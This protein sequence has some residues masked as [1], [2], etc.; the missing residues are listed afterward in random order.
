[1]PS[2]HWRALAAIILSTVPFARSAAQVEVS[3]L[4]FAGC[5]I[6]DLGPWSPPLTDTID[7]A[8]PRRVELDT[9]G[10]ELGKGWRLIPNIQYPGGRTFPGTPN[11]DVH[12]DTIVLAWSNGFTPTFIRLR[13]QG[14]L[15]VG[16]AVAL[17]DA[18]VIGEPPRPRA[19]V[20]LRRR[21]CGAG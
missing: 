3:P 13:P 1:M 11:W 5:F 10:I 15:L 7:Y 8:V 4:R 6:L 21:Q 9:A 20:T 12:R 19:S 16:E 14:A 18:Y 2:N 17:T